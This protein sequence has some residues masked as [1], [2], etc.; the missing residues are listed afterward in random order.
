MTT[1]NKVEKFKAK[2]I[3]RSFKQ[4]ES[5]DYKE[6]FLP[7]IKQVAIRLMI[8]TAIKNKWIMKHINIKITF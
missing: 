1:N 7:T 6:I 2:L 4:E 3:I 5:I 8:F